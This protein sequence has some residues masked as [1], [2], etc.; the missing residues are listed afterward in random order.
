MIIMIIMIII[1]ITILI[2]IIKII[3]IMIIIIIITSCNPCTA[4]SYTPHLRCMREQPT[5][6]AKGRS[7]YDRSNIIS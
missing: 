3:I 6:A 5:L 4:R 1:K 7:F 2:I